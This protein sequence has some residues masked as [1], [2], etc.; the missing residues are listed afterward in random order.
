VSLPPGRA[1]R[2][3]RSDARAGSSM[4]PRGTPCACPLPRG[5]AT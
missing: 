4:C 5:A 1:A 3:A 2:C